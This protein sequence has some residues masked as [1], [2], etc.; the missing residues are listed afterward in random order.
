MSLLEKIIFVADYT[1]PGRK[2]PEAQSLRQKLLAGLDLQ[3]AVLS[4]VR[5]MLKWKENLTKVKNCSLA[6]KRKS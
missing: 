4:K 5:Y 6:H 2:F 3:Q 1:E